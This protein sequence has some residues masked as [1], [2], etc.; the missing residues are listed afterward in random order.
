MFSDE[1]C[2]KP[3]RLLPSALNTNTA[4][5]SIASESVPARVLTTD[6]EGAD[7]ST[8]TLLP[9]PSPSTA[10]SSLHADRA[11]NENNR[12]DKYAIFLIVRFI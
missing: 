5:F 8:E 4:T 1:V 7:N 9:V 6:S 2:V 10:S 3:R 11:K 12:I